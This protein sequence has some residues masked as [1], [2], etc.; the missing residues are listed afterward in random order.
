MP[1]ILQSYD[2]VVKKFW[3][4]KLMFQNRKCS[5][6]CNVVTKTQSTNTQLNYFL[7]LEGIL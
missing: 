4:V 6:F 5:K 2:I 3:T 1:L 7:M